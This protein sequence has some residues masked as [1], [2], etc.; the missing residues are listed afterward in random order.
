VDETLTPEQAWDDAKKH[1]A[2]DRD[3]V[4]PDGTYTATTYR[5]E[6]VNSKSSTRPML[7]LT[8]KILGPTAQG[9][10]VWHR[11]ML[12]R[13]EG[14]PYLARDL[15]AYGVDVE[16]VPSL[17]TLEGHLATMLDQEFEIRVS[18][19]GEFRNVR[20]LR[21]IDGAGHSVADREG[22]PF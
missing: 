12:D 7:V 6:V 20:I 19:L 2:D 1:A 22:L 9:R 3:N 8:Y 10:L 14:W 15:D 4:V 13:V 17:A 16:G 11:H 18:T 21:R 5:A